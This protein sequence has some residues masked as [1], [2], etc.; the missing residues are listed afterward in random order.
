MSNI[1]NELKHILGLCTGGKHQCW[2][3]E[4][5]DKVDDKYDVKFDFLQ[6]G[7][8]NLLLERETLKARKDELET[9]LDV[10]GSYFEGNPPL[11]FE[12]LHDRYDRLK[13]L[14]KQIKEKS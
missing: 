5:S 10:I 8:I 6:L 11:H 3:L 7:A 9:C 12:Q 2:F 1:S 13:Q 4:T 14:N